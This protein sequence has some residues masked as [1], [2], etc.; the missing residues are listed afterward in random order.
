MPTPFYHLDVAREI[1]TS[2][3]INPDVQQVLLQYSGPFYLGNI[4]PDVQTVAKTKR[5][6][7]HFY[8][9]K[10]FDEAA[11]APID[12]LQNSYPEL[13]DQRSFSVQKRTFLAGYYCHL[14]ADIR[15]MEEIFLPKF[16]LPEV[17]NI[18]LIHNVLRSYLDEVAYHNLSSGVREALIKTTPYHWLPFVKDKALCKLR[19]W[20]VAQ[21]ESED[22]VLTVK[23]FAERTGAS[24]QQFRGI[25]ENPERMKDE[26]FSIITEEDVLSYRQRVVIQSIEMVE[27]MFSG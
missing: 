11:D 19:D 22:K 15:W 25:L 6:S 1:L 18:P 17:E 21:L 9:A 20:I 26:I 7:T 5:S 4:A 24:E 2:P 16:I 10:H 23:V 14:I 13:A 12:K 8:S 3:Q 27:G